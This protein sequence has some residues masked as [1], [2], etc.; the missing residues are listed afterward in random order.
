M[1][2]TQRH[3]AGMRNRAVSRVPSA[4]ASSGRSHAEQAHWKTCLHS[5]VLAMPVGCT[6]P[7]MQALRACAQFWACLERWSVCFT[8]QCTNPSKQAVDCGERLTVNSNVQTKHV[9]K[10][11]QPSVSSQIDLMASHCV[12]AIQHVSDIA[13]CDLKRL[14]LILTLSHAIAICNAKAYAFVTAHFGAQVSHFGAHLAPSGPLEKRDLRLQGGGQPHQ[15]LHALY[16][17]GKPPAD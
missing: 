9:F 15:H 11:H 3:S 16:H 12:H 2:R 17:P 7:V 10:D 13:C 14:K 5:A 4:H 6:G 8:Y 1:S